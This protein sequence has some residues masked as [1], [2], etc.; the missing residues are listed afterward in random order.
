MLPFS[1]IGEGFVYHLLL[2]VSQ[3][4]RGHL[5]LPVDGRAQSTGSAGGGVLLARVV[6]LLVC[7]SDGLL[8]HL[9]RTTAAP[10]Q[11]LQ[12]RIHDGIS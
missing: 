10:L 3:D 9:L 1:E 8:L 12:L 7:G 4:F 2:V 5:D 6:A 11:L